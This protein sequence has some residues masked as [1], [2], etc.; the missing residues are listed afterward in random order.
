M[1]TKP[2]KIEITLALA[3]NAASIAALESECLECPWS[4]KQIAE[5]I[6]SPGYTFFVACL[7][8]TFAGYIGIE[9][10][11]DEGNICNVAVSPNARRA[12]VATALVEALVDEAKRRGAVRLFLEVNENN[13]AAKSLYD[14]FGF[15][16]SYRRPNYYG[17]EAAF[18][19]VKEIDRF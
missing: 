18:V 9:W 4:E 11:L 12:G 14:K 1:K 5:S 16:V 7:G 17:S 6:E 3:E 8:G 10:C 15:T 2:D 13:A 19:M